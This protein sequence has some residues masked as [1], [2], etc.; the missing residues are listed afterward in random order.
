MSFKIRRTPLFFQPQRGQRNNP[1]FNIKGIWKASCAAP[2]IKTPQAIAII[3]SSISGASQ[4]AA[5]I[6]VKLS[7][8]GVNAG[9]AK[10]P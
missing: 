5:A 9:T 4:I 1:S 7:K 10:R 2:A 8:T 6:K 3:G